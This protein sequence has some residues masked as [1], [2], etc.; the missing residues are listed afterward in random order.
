MEF[1]VK[2]GTSARR[3]PPCLGAGSG[4]VVDLGHE[5]G[6]AQPRRSPHDFLPAGGVEF[7]DDQR[8]E[9]RPLVVDQAT[10]SQGLVTTVAFAP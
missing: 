10:D 4:H 7:A 2:Q 8:L 9:R 6:V 1:V 5:R 3:G